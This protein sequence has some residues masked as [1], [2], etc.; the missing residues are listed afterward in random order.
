MAMNSHEIDEKTKLVRDLCDLILVIGEE[1][2][3]EDCK[4]MELLT[5]LAT[6]HG[7]SKTQLQLLKEIVLQYQ[8]N[9][10]FT[11]KDL[12]E[13]EGKT[14]SALVRQLNEL[15]DKGFIKRN[16]KKQDRRKVFLIPTQKGINTI[17]ALIEQEKDPWF[18][19]KLT[20]MPLEDIK[21]L[22]DRFS[23][24]VKMLKQKEA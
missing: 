17:M 10:T 16:R 3:N 4:N 13:M 15:E 20:S 18:F 7:L 8:E 1:L 5:H 11:V 9:K 14:S 22:H 24:I 2:R 12:A 21:Y 23:Q 19:P 6:Q